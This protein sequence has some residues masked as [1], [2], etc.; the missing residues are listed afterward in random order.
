VLGDEL[1]Q[2]GHKVCF[3][4][5]FDR[6]SW[7]GNHLRAR[8]FCLH[9]SNTIKAHNRENTLVFID[10]YSLEVFQSVK[11]KYP[12]T[13]VVTIQDHFS[14]AF[15]PNFSIFQ[16]PDESL[17]PNRLALNSSGLVAGPKYLLLRKSLAKL[18]HASGSSGEKKNV[19]VMAG[20]S[21]ATGFIAAFIDSGIIPSDS[22]FFHIIGDRPRGCDFSKN[23]VKFHSL[24]TRP[25]DIGVHF[26]VATSMA[27]VTA[28]EILSARIPL[29]VSA[30]TENQIALHDFL[31]SSGFATSIEILGKN[32]VWCFTSSDLNESLM[33]ASQRTLKFND[34]DYLGASRI[35]AKLEEKFNL[36]F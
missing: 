36:R 14:P 15:Q 24:G 7:V 13:P 9:S 10:S 19:L 20:G 2:K 28:L 21:D 17:I 31:V 23:D 16:V 26:G 27:G 18:Q 3:F 5:D 25:E 12:S 34:L 6:P 1:L 8:G 29:A 32:S 33:T 35:L 4:G 22:Y 11:I 30:S